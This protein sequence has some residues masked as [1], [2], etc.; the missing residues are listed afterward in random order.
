M[1]YALGADDL[2]FVTAAVVHRTGNMRAVFECNTWFPRHYLLTEVRITSL[3][4]DQE[5]QGFDMGFFQLR[6]PVFYVLKSEFRMTDL[7]QDLDDTRYLTTLEA[8]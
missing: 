4:V 3:S 6:G 7:E 8:P 5:N 1:A 2:K